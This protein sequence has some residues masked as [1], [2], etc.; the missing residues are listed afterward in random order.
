MIDKLNEKTHTID[1]F[2]IYRISTA[3]LNKHNN[4]L[5]FLFDSFG[6]TTFIENFFFVAKPQNAFNWNRFNCPKVPF[7]SMFTHMTKRFSNR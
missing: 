3:K 1:R 5:P 4:Q 7:L 6:L 2:R